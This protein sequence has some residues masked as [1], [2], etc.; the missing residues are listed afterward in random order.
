VLL[1]AD[2]EL[3]PRRIDTLSTLGNQHQADLVSDNLLLCPEDAPGST[4]PML[5][6]GIL[7]AGRWMSPAEF[8]FGNIGSRHSPRVSYGFLKPIIRRSF[9]QRH[10]LRYCEH[11]RYGEDFLMY[12]ACLLKQGRWWMTSE[13]MYRYRI[14]SGSL[15]ESASA[16]DLWRISALQESLLR[17]DPMVAADVKLAAALRRHK[18]K[19]DRWYYYRAFTDAVKAGASDQA[20][21]LLFESTR[22]FYYIF[23][24][25][26]TQAPKITRK[27]L[28]GGYCS[29]P[30]E[31]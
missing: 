16:G 26:M 23:V 24:E 19:S 18:A 30:S 12:V 5:P 6:S 28:R 21:Q 20:R 31:T 13:P 9:L 15:S 4:E 29:S 10:D 2:D 3:M 8:V 7:P 17:S 27:A 22:S 25:S 14:R 1:D 11:N